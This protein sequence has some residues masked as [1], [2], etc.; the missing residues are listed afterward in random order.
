MRLPIL[1]AS[2]LVLALAVPA[3]AGAVAT[4]LPGQA[5]LGDLD[6]RTGKVAPTAAQKQEA[7]GLGARVE[8][9]RYGTPAS[10]IASDGWLTSAA[11]GSASAGRARLHRLAP[12]AVQALRGRRH[13]ARSRQRLQA[14]RRATGTPS[15]S[16]RRSA[17]RPP[18]TTA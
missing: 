15:S 14:R 3:S 7:S 16:A 4:I 12:L 2:L 6:A 8:W 17:A 1:V 18:A 5:G 13:C 11:S 9:N 10:L